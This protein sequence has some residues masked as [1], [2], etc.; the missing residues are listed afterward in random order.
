MPRHYASKAKA[1]DRELGVGEGQIGPVRR[2]L[3]EV[4]PVIP[5]VFGGFGEVSEEVHDLIGTLAYL[6]HAMESRAG[7]REGLRVVWANQG[8]YQEKIKYGHSQGKHQLPLG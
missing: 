8:G 2:R 1:M 3:G 6:R 7:G 4:G 5:L